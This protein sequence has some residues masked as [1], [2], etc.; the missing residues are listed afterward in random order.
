MS[1]KKNPVVGEHDFYRTVTVDGHVGVVCSCGAQSPVDAVAAEWWAA[2]S[3]PPKAD[4]DD[5]EESE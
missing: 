4:A 3:A 5:A 2:H 1:A